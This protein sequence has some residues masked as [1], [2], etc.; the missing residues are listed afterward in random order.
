[1]AALVRLIV[2]RHTAAKTLRLPKLPVPGD[3]IKLADGTSV[4]VREI[5][6]SKRGIVA[7]EVRAKPAS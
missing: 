6:P 7:A 1:M 4:V 5:E 2:D 3:L